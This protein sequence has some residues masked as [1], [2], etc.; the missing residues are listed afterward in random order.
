MQRQIDELVSSFSNEEV[1]MGRV[2]ENAALKQVVSTVGGMSG[3]EHV[4]DGGE[5]LYAAPSVEPLLSEEDGSDAGALL[6]KL[7]DLIGAS[8]GRDIAKN[9]LA[10][11]LICLTQGYIT[12]LAGLPVPAKHL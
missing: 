8:Y 9:D 2:L 11:V 3:S 5:C 10:N 6:S 1:L 4:G 12:T 7:D